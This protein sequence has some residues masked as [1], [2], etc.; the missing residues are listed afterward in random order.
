MP[1]SIP[2]K[3]ESVSKGE[4]AGGGVILLNVSIPF[5]RESVSKVGSVL[6]VE[7]SISVSIPFK[8]ESVS[9][10]NRSVTTP[11]PI[12]TSVS[13]PFKRESVS[14]EALREELSW[15]VIKFQF[16][17]NGKAYPKALIAGEVFGWRLRVSIPFK[18]ESVSKG[19]F[20]ATIVAGIKGVSIPFKRESVSKGQSIRRTPRFSSLF[21]FPSNGKA[22]PKTQIPAEEVTGVQI[23]AFQFPSNGKAYP[24]QS[25]AKGLFCPAS[26]NSLQTGKRIQSRQLPVCV[27][28]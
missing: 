16:P 9:K 12:G 1:V 26:F 15:W 5:K 8:R 11:Q 2:F 22:Y 4:L 14:K 3:R 6:S 24:K 25:T 21:Q 27:P 18:R 7:Y 10:A 17:S 28:A 19:T 20:L 23:N 13:I